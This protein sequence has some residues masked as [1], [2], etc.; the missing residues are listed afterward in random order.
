MVLVRA[1]EAPI[2]R[3]LLHTN[4]ALMI[5]ILPLC[6]VPGMKPGPRCGQLRAVTGSHS[7][8]AQQ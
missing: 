5:T 7:A 4:N 8:T 2:V 1:Q 3:Q 6:H